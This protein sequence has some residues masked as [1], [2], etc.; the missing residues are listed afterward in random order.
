MFKPDSAVT[1]LL[2]ADG[3]EYCGIY[4]DGLLEDDEL[5]VVERVLDWEIQSEPFACVSHVETG[6]WWVPLNHTL[7]PW[8]VKRPIWLGVQ[9]DLNRSTGV[10]S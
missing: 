3:F 9:Q 2:E 4:R 8:H 7:E 1:W 5:S 10:E 6:A